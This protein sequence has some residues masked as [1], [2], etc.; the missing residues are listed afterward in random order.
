MVSTLFLSPVQKVEVSIH[1]RLGNKNRQKVL[2]LSQLSKT[3]K[4][5]NTL[6]GI[7]ETFSI[8]KHIKSTL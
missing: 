3:R 4:S 6:K 5:E 1:W 7:Q 8:L 2:T